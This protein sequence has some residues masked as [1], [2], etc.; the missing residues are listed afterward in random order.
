MRPRSRLYW[1]V[2]LTLALSLGS[3]APAFARSA[4][5]S[6]K[7][8]H[9]SHSETRHAASRSVLRNALT[10]DPIAIIFGVG[11]LEYQRLIAPA[12]A[13]A[14]RILFGWGFG[15]G[16]SWRFF[17]LDNVPAPEGLYVGPGLDLYGYTYNFGGQSASAMFFMPKGEI[18]Y[19]FMFP[20]SERVSFVVSPNAALGMSFGSVSVGG[21][22]YS[23]GFFFGLGCGLGIAF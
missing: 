11:N 8:S 6:A 3:A 20:M 14:G 5:S 7:T 10:L 13:L 23:G 9:V 18:G 17:L 12:S 22:T 2:V 1:P 21:S 15:V 19:R 4:R 16:A